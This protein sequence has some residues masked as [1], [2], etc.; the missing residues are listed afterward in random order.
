MK[1]RTVVLFST[2]EIQSSIARGPVMGILDDGR[3]MHSTGLLEKYLGEDAL[4]I[5]ATTRPSFVEA[6]NWWLNLVPSGQVFAPT[7]CGSDANDPVIKDVWVRV[8]SYLGMNVDPNN[9]RS[10]MQMRDHLL[11]NKWIGRPR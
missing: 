1:I 3:E 9:F 2:S 11:Q 7:R 5:V 4:I 10:W 8:F 6:D